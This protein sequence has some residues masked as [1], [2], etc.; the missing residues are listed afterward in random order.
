LQT[1]IEKIALANMSYSTAIGPNLSEV[2]LEKVY[3]EKCKLSF[4]RMK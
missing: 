2:F 4:P 3:E 1:F